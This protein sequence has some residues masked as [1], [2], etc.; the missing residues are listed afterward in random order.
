MRR[1]QSHRLSCRL[2]A[3]VV[4]AVLVVSWCGGPWRRP[5]PCGGQGGGKV[6]RVVEGHRARQWRS[7]ADRLRLGCRFPR[8]RR[9]D[10]RSGYFRLVA[11]T[12]WGTSIVLPP[13]FWSGGVLWQGV[14]IKATHR[15][16]GDRLVIEALGERHGLT[17]RL[18]VT[19][20]PPGDGRIAAE[21]SGRSEGKVALDARPGEAFKVVML[22][23]MRVS[24]KEF[25]ASAVLIGDRPPLAFGDKSKTS[26]FFVAAPRPSSAQRFRPPGRSVRPGRRGNW[27]RRSR[28]CSMRRC[29]SRAVHA[30][31]Q[32]QRRQSRA[33][34]VSRQRA[35][36]L[37]LHH[38]RLSSHEVGPT[39]PVSPRSRGM[40]RLQRRGTHRCQIRT[41]RC[42]IKN[43]SVSDQNFEV[44]KMI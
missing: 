24:P 26:G 10:V 38:H 39:R 15:V 25:D 16:D 18:D 32:S 36:L 33:L 29:R 43:E 13:P 2:M 14:P 34:G 40:T 6:C 21:V 9:A 17:L 23:S 5:P 19:L 12:T 27:P 44:E 20:S 30:E 42:Q 1:F 11:G 3:P 35:R 41:N 7:L 31:H 22:S 8:G 4:V 28:S 37:A